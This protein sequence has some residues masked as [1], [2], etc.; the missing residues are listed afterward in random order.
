V[1]A[2]G[3]EVGIVALVDEAVEHDVGVFEF[4]AFAGVHGRDKFTD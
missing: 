1:R 2:V 3:R 4:G